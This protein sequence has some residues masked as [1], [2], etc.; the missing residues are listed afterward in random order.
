M[1]AP[2]GTK[3]VQDM[4]S[5][6]ERSFGDTA[7]VQ[8]F[9]TD[10]IRWIN[11]GQMEIIS[12]NPVLKKIAVTPTF[13][14]VGIY[15]IPPDCIQMEM[16]QVDNVILKAVSWE[17]VRNVTYEGA[18]SGAPQ[19]WAIYANKI[20]MWPSPSVDGTVQIFYACRPPDVTSAGSY[21]SIPDRYFDRLK[22]YVMSRAY[23]M[24][25]DWTA[26]QVQRDQFEANLLALS[27]ADANIQG[28]YLVAQDPGF[29]DVG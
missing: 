5:D 12:K 28:P 14:D 3:T 20:F 7:K 13:K 2:I 21:L 16:I 27:N 10:I 24:D 6:V 11:S 17:E 29:E 18:N 19:T 26:H 15:D 9:D 4:I 1:T 23:E 25:E 22:E 8:L